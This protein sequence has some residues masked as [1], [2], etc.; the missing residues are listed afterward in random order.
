MGKL[1]GVIQFTGR[2]GQVVGY[3]GRSSRRYVRAR[4]DEV[5]N[6]R[7]EAQNIQRM[8][9]AT[10]AVG[11][12]KL[13]AILSNSF[14]GKSYGAE[15][16]A[17]ARQLWMRQL[18]VSDILSDDNTL[19]YIKKG[20]QRFAINPYQVSRGSLSAP[21]ISFVEGEETIFGVKGSVS[22]MLTGGTASQ[23][24][25]NVQVGR[26]W[27][28]IAVADKGVPQAAYCRFAFKD[29]TTA[30]F[31]EVEGVGYR[32]NPDAIDL[33]KAEGNWGMLIFSEDAVGGADVI[34]IDASGML[35]AEGNDDQDMTAAAALIISDK[36]GGLRSTSYLVVNAGYVGP[37]YSAS[38]AAP[39]FGNVTTEVNVSSDVYL[40]NSTNVTE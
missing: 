31:I 28:I 20:E 22:M 10:A 1:S 24:F 11:V 25:P 40:N 8:I 2:L 29:N 38:V 23:C 5:K 17:Y 34:T 39:T 4:V 7:S 30:A 12:S 19:N 13:K 3:K 21:A 36:E 6:P 32:L 14:E 37:L 16:L 27:T 26:Q 18:R 15:S 33:T 35:L 9:L